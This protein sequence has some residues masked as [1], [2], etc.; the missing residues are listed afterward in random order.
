MSFAFTTLILAIGLAGFLMQAYRRFGD[1][2]HPVV[3]LAPMFVILYVLLPAYILFQG[4]LQRYLS[5]G[6]V[7]KIQVINMLGCLV[8]V[9]GIYLGSRAR[10]ALPET[11]PSQSSYILDR[12]RFS[13]IV[14]GIVKSAPF[15]MRTKVQR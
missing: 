9:A 4:D 8:M 6:E 5:P 3:L 7:G 12:L 14:L 15:Q 11:R 1:P 10:T 13:S 2:F